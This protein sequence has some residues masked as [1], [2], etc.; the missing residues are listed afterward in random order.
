MVIKTCTLLPYTWLLIKLKRAD[1]RPSIRAFKIQKATTLMWH[2]TPLAF[3]RR[4]TQEVVYGEWR[5]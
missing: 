4:H 2:D 1:R 3:P 5:V